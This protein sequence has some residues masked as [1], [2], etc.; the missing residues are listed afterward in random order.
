MTWL[1]KFTPER[2]GIPSSLIWATVI[3]VVGAMATV[4]FRDALGLAHFMLGHGDESMVELAT[5]LPWQLRIALAVLGGIV[6]GS[7]LVIVE[8]YCSSNTGDY[9]EAIAH[10]DGRI[11]VCQTLLKSVSSLCTIAS[12]GSIGREGAI[13]QLAAMSGSIAGRIRNVDPATRRLLA[14]CGAAAGVASAYNA[15]FAS[16]LFVSEIVL[17]AIFMESFGPILV[18]AI[19]ANLTMRELPGY[20][21]VYEMPATPPVPLIELAAFVVLGMIIGV[22]VPQFLRLLNAS[23]AAFRAL[24]ISIIP[25]MALG[26]A[27]VGI[28]SVWV[29][30]VWGNGYSV[31]NSLL[32]SPWTWSAVLLVVICKILATSATVGSGAVGGVFTPTLFVGAS[33]GYLFGL[34]IHAVWPAASQPSTYA[35]IGMGGFLAAATSAPLMSILMIFEMTL[36]Y[37]IMLPLMLTCVLAYYVAKAAGGGAMYEIT[38]LRMQAE[39]IRMHLRAIQMSDLIQPAETVL[40]LQASFSE[41]TQ[42]FL[43]FHV[44]HVYIVDSENRYLGVVALQDLTSTL[45]SQKERDG[46]TA[47]DFLRRDYL[48]VITP[49]M[50]LDEALHCFLMHQGER[51]PA[52]HSTEDPQLLG[53]VN[54]TALLDAYYRLNR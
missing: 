33:I 3:G 38:I 41:L 53:V 5:E 12:G 44:K 45:L 8:R 36:S 13:V 15:P 35:I 24:G 40:P 48:E 51:L 1:R 11:S 29:P 27:I 47:Q 19:V 26:G 10:N 49:E 6:A 43:R 2:I 23:K 21:P 14:A 9:M 42:M 34:L 52:I 20:H 4:G 18:A 22:I 54:K 32:H 7:F 17:G 46:M 37:Q 16:A 30:Q 31:V 28:M 50:S 39:Q 25:R